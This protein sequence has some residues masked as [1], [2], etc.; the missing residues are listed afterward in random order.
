MTQSERQGFL[1]RL[2]SAARLMEGQDAESIEQ[3][4]TTS[5]REL[6]AINR[7]LA[8]GDD[9]GRQMGQNVTDIMAPSA[10]VAIDQS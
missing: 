5:E 9:A 4:L 1:S 2:G 6:A 10:D 8:E 3:R 7:R